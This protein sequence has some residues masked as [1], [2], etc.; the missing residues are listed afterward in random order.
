M[1]N[2]A[3]SA[4]ARLQCVR[5]RGLATSWI[6]NPHPP[7]TR[8]L[9]LPPRGIQRVPLLPEGTFSSSAG[10]TLVWRPA[11]FRQHGHWGRSA[12]VERLRATVARVFLPKGSRVA[13][14]GSRRPPVQWR[15]MDTSTPAARQPLSAKIP[16]RGN[17]APGVWSATA[18]R[19]PNSVVE[20]F[21][22]ADWSFSSAD[23]RRNL[24]P[25]PA[26]YVLDLPA[27]AIELLQPSFG[28]VDPFCGS[29]STLEASARVG[30]PSVGIDLN[31]IACLMSR[32]RVSEWQGN[33]EQEAAQHARALVDAAKNVSDDVV[34]RLRAKVP[35]VDHWFE[36]WAQR[37]LAG[38]TD[39][40]DSIPRT[41]PWHDRVALSI[42]S[43]V[44]K[45][46]RQDSDTRYA[47]VDK[48][49]DERTGLKMLS[50]AVQRTGEYLARRPALLTKDTTV[51][52]RDARD[53]G[54][55]PDA[56]LD[57]AVFSPPYPNAYEYWLY[58]KYRMY[59]LNHD[60]IAVRESEIGARPHY[61]KSKNPHTEDDF[62]QQMGDVLQELARVLRP[63]SP[64]VIVV[65]DSIIRGRA[66]DNRELLFDVGRGLGFSP[67][68]ALLRSIARTRSSF[69]S[70][71]RK[72]RS[73]EHVLLLESPA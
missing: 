44:V 27:Q 66:I 36:G 40:L 69:N 62:A 42:S 54:P 17:E 55:V 52:E 45:I 18:G 50:S 49:L 14:E 10:A 16:R 67:R 71:H 5:P 6:W 25:Y 32:V 29:G 9:S 20:R 51:Y 60:P 8:P 59:W 64:V 65:G 2:L 12:E 72:G 48:G 19:I 1:K 4:R 23:T 11:W 28:V 3:S 34:E 63:E 33:D 7:M 37:V 43:A 41:D 24:H 57:A 61:F 68:G 70:G 58:H 31:P 39:Y 21:V 46:G 35:N 22:G 13:T 47:A 15:A 38:A 73:A 53:L 26:R 56:S 30:L